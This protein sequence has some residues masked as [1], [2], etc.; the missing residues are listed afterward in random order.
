[1]LGTLRVG[2][3][4]AACTLTRG[5]S[6]RTSGALTGTSRGLGRGRV[7]LAAG[8]GRPP[9]APEGTKVHSGRGQVV[10]LACPGSVLWL[11]KSARDV[12]LREATSVAA[13]VGD[14]G[15][16]SGGTTF[17]SDRTSG[18]QQLAGRRAR[19]GLLVGGRCPGPSQ[20]FWPSRVVGGSGLGSVGLVPR[21]R[22]HRMTGTSELR[23]PASGCGQ[24]PLRCRGKAGEAIRV[25]E[26]TRFFGAV[27]VESQGE[28]GCSSLK[29]GLQK[30]A[31]RISGTIVA[32]LSGS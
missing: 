26:L 7:L 1:V 32:D 14:G 30:S 21:R 6:T 12:G 5:F 3:Y 15:L 28:H 27:S 23:L 25:R 17:G 18:A 19:G 13:G 24:Q 11:Q 31:R 9:P 29:C 2:L 20:A 22:R 4:T 8:G 10:R 16:A